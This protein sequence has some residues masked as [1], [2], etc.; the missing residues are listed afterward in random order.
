LS[1]PIPCQTL[2][3]FYFSLEAVAKSASSCDQFI[4]QIILEWA[5]FTFLNSVN[6]RSSWLFLL[7]RA[8]DL[9]LEHDSRYWSHLENSN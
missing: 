6:Y 4:P 7:K 3:D 1:A 8:H 5:S 9:S 2:T